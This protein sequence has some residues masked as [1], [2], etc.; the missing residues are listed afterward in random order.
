MRLR[1]ETAIATFT[2]FAITS[3]LSVINSIDSIVSGCRTNPKADCISNTLVSL[4]L[5]ILIVCFLG[6]ILAVGYFAQE[7]RSSRLSYLLIGIEGCTALL[8]LFE[9]KQSPDL[10]EKGTNFIACLLAVW[11]IILAWRLASAKGGRIVNHRVR[12]T[13]HQQP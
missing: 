5:L 11:V 3:G 6:A 7:K 2:Q 10:I 13:P 8:Y 1:Y 12:R 4:I 9:A